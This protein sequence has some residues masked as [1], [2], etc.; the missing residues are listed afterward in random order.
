MMDASE[1]K[2]AALSEE[3]EKLRLKTNVKEKLLGKTLREFDMI[4]QK[5]AQKQEELRRLNTQLEIAK[6][7]L[8]QSFQRYVS[9][10]IV[11]EI[12]QR[13][14]PV[15]LQGERKTVS[16]LLSD[17]RGFTTLSEQMEPEDLV[18][19]LNSYFSA[20]IDIIFE[21][22]GTLDKF[23]GDAV[24][25]LFGAPVSHEDDPLRSVKAAMAM[26]AKLRDLND[27]W[28]TNGKPSIR[29]GIGISTGEVVV[30][31][32]GSERRMEYTV[33][34]QDVNYAQRIEALTKDLPA[35]V[36]ISEST[37]ERIKEHVVV[38]K[39]GPLAIKGKKD[40]ITVYGVMGFVRT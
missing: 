23:M 19:F 14:E 10:Q 5:L 33:I 26:Q 36:L 35:N 17:I 7:L 16:I 6:D 39:F 8:K 12:L 25:A 21:H 9:A 22:E 2:I 13:S 1:R 34:G 29:I 31:N 18:Q 20:M 30:G 24:L 11:E 4:G 27:I 32:I 28:R 40:P 37:Y 15:N 3:I 38:E